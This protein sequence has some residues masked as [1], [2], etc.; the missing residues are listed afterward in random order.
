MVW[1]SWI[2]VSSLASPQFKSWSLNTESSSKKLLV[3]MIFLHSIRQGNMNRITHGQKPVHDEG[4]RTQ[5][6][7]SYRSWILW[8]LWFNSNSTLH[9]LILEISG[10][11]I[12]A[13]LTATG[14]IVVNDILASCHSNLGMKTLQQTFFSVYRTAQRWFFSANSLSADAEELQEIDDDLP[15]GV[16][17]LTSVLDLFVPKSFIY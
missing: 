11:G 1:H 7:L 17:Y 8:I 15:T 14:D 12:Y 16:R 4:N 10:K 6:F 9:L 3:S 2:L 13:P 5:L